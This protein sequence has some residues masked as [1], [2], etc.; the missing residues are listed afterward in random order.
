MSMEIKNNNILIA[1]IPLFLG[2][3]FGYFSN[4]FSFSPANQGAQVLQSDIEDKIENNYD[5]YNCDFDQVWNGKECFT[6]AYSNKYIKNSNVSLENNIKIYG[7]SISLDDFY[8]NNINPNDY[9]TEEDDLKS[10]QH[11][12]KVFTLWSNFSENWSLNVCPVA[13]N[14]CPGYGQNVT[15]T[16]IGGGSG[17]QD[18]G[19]EDSN[20]FSTPGRGGVGGSTGGAAR[21]NFLIPSDGLLTSFSGK[22]GFPG[23]RTSHGAVPNGATGSSVKAFYDG[24]MYTLAIARGAIFFPINSNYVEYV[25]VGGSATVGV[26]SSVSS[27]PPL[28][29]NNSISNAIYS[30][31]PGGSGILQILSSTPTSS[32]GICNGGGGGSGTVGWTTI[33]GVFG[34][35]GPGGHGGY[36]NSFPGCMGHGGNYGLTA[37]FNG[38]SGIVIVSW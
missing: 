6:P 36:N 33:L 34:S 9:R 7:K 35:G 17:G 4:G 10:E 13:T 5:I 12:T 28:I 30:D 31:V 27:N 8:S 19:E 29:L 15:F 14:E 2:I 32:G 24:N 16:L 1:V 38:G 23:L 21:F 11:G 18:G 20:G 26:P 37:G 22:I 3:F 25:S